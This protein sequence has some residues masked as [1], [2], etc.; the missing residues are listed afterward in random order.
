[1]S[2]G[3][4]IAFALAYSL[5]A[6]APGP[7]VLLVVSHAVAHG[8]RT[9]GAVVAATVL[10]DAACLVAAVGGVG[11]ILAAS[12]LAFTVLKLAGAAY[13]VFLGVK[14]WRAPPV[15]VAATA[16]AGSLWRVFVHAFLTAVLNPKS[17]LFFMVFVPQF[18]DTKSPLPPQ[19]AAMAAS[20]LICGVLVDGGYTVFAASLRR[21]IRAPGAQGVVNRLAGGTLIAEGAIAAVSRGLVL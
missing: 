3:T 21:F 13:L 17:I 7:V 20:I 9:A 2:P 8:R 12:A 1:M 11:A 10:G 4:W 14:L 16:P 19:L 15:P 18:L 6:L 5:M